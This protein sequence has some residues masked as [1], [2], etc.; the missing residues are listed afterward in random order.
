MKVVII[1]YGLCNLLSV[2]NALR[3][4]G[5]DST[6]TP[7]PEKLKGA[8][9]LI[10]PG[11]GAF[12]DGMKGLRDRGFIRP[13]EEY[14]ASGR[15]LLGICLGMQLLFDKSFEF[16]EF[17]GLHLIPGEVVPVKPAG[18]TGVPCKIPH[19]GW[20]ALLKSTRDWRGTILGDIPAGAEMYFV[21]S[22]QGVPEYKEHVLAETD[23]CGNRFCSVVACGNV[24]GCQFHPEKSAA[25]GLTILRSFL[26]I[27]GV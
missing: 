26:S 7:D 23:Y 18:S 13:I 15:P 9:A 16:G 6:V 14:V 2:H 19:V 8:D 27:K 4:F 1:D 10:L 21:H 22:Y 24:F 17:E 12:E 3:S 11:V 25:D 20:N 5:V